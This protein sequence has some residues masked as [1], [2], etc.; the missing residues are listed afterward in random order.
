MISA[1]SENNEKGDENDEYGGEPSV[2][3]VQ[4]V[5]EQLVDRDVE[6]HDTGHVGQTPSTEPTII[7]RMSSSL[8]NRLADKTLWGHIDP[9]AE[10]P[11][12]QEVVCDEDIDAMLA[13]RRARNRQLGK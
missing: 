4:N 13:A 10:W 3:P 6:M 12:W 7:Q 11:E 2:G 5:E 8:E 1:T 9:R